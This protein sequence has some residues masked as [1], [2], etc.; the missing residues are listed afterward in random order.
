MNDVFVIDKTISKLNNS[1]R[2]NMNFCGFDLKIIEQ[3]L[4][5]LRNERLKHTPWINRNPNGYPPQYGYDIND[6]GVRQVD[7]VLE[8]IRKHI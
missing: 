3:G 6:K 1:D 5:L 4:T 7:S 8:Y 2:F